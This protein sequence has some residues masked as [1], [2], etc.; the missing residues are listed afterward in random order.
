MKCTKSNFSLLAALV[1]AA[2]L[3]N[4]CTQAPV[5]VTSEIEEANKA[6]V[7][8]R[9]SSDPEA[10]SLLY[11]VDAR[12]LP[13]NGTLINGREAIK[14]YW[15]ESMG[16]ATSELVLETVNAEGYG[17]MAIE[18]GRYV[19]KVGSQEVDRGKYMVTWKKEGRKWLLHQDIWNSDLPLPQARAA[20]NE[21][22]WVVSNRIKADKVN[23]FEEFT[24]SLLEPAAREN[25][26]A[27]RNTVRLLRPVEPIKDGT[28]TYFFLMD[29]AN[30]PDG[31][32]MADGLTAKYGKEKS[33]EYL[34][35]FQDCLVDGQELIATVQTK[36]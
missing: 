10:M 23:Q 15:S 6:F 21:T 11:T 16:Q 36:W 18:E 32:N 26:P 27:K 12:L 22:V 1:L 9:E 7:E 33:D 31:Y 5:D 14:A 30:S 34:K 3:L 19:I 28:F 8:I 35:M 2:L 17:N 25:S 13:A 20:A 24:F 29:P 4:S